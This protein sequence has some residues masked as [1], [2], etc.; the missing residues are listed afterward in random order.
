MNSVTIYAQQ[1][2][3]YSDE[4]DVLFF[5]SGTYMRE[6]SKDKSIL[7]RINLNIEKQ[8]WAYNVQ[9]LC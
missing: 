2:L 1:P 5:G 9:V 6:I 4:A 7:D 3:E 8:F